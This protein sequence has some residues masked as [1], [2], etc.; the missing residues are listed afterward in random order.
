MTLDTVGPLKPDS[1]T[2]SALEHGLF[3]RRSW[4]NSRTLIWRKLVGRDASSA[5]IGILRLRALLLL[6]A[7]LPFAGAGR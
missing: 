3:A 2:R 1:L 7:I 6:N 5:R 4:Y